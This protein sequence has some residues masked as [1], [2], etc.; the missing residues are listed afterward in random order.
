MKV[1]LS[2]VR[3]SPV[4]LTVA[5]L[6]L[7]MAAMI[8]YPRDRLLSGPDVEGVTDEQLARAR[9]ALALSR[10]RPLFGFRAIA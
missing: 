3:R 5:E 6:L 8:E 9:L 2:T 1:V 4:L 10:K 7:D